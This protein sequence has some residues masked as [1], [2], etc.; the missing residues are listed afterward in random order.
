MT[1]YVNTEEMRRAANTI[2]S[3]AETM[4]RAAGQFDDAVFRLE[5]LIGSGWQNNIE[6]LVECLE[7]LEAKNES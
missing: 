1:E 3:A 7:N 2:D 5:K 4:Q 6:R